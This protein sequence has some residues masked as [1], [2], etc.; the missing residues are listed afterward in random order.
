MNLWDAKQKIIAMTMAVMMLPWSSFNCSF[1]RTDRS[2]NKDETVIDTAS[3]TDAINNDISID[4]D[5]KN[6]GGIDNQN[7]DDISAILDKYKND[8]YNDSDIDN[9]IPFDE[10]SI[11]ISVG[12]KLESDMVVDGH[13]VLDSGTLDLNGHKLTVKGDFLHS[14]GIVDINN[15]LLEIYGSYRM[16]KY[17]VDDMG[18]IVY[19]S[20]DSTLIMN[21]SNDKIL[22]N[23]DFIIDTIHDNNDSKLLS[24]GNIE[25]KGDICFDI[26]T[27]KTGFMP[28]ENHTIT[29]SSD[30]EQ[31]ISYSYTKGYT[32]NGNNSHIR[33]IINLN[34]SE[35]G[36]KIKEPLYISGKIVTGDNKLSGPIMI[37]SETTFDNDYFDGD[38]SILQNIRFDSAFT[39]NGNLTV[40]KMSN[41][42]GCTINDL[43]TV[44]GDVYNYYIIEGNG[45][46]VVNGNMYNEI[47]LYV[48]DLS[49]SGNL[50]N[51]YYVKV[52]S[53]YVEGDVIADDKISVI[54]GHIKGSLISNEDN[55]MFYY[56]N[57]NVIVEGD[58]VNITFRSQQS[59]SKVCIYGNYTTNGLTF[60]GDACE[61]L[62]IKGNIEIPGD[63]KVYAYKLILSGDSLQEIKNADKLNIKILEIENHSTEG[64][65]SDSIISYDTL[66][67]NNYNFSYGATNVVTGWTLEDDEIIE[68]DLVL[69]EGNLDLKGHKL[70]IEGDLVQMSGKVILNNGT[71]DIKGSY[72]MQSFSSDEDRENE[73]YNYGRASLIMSYDKDEVIISKDFV[74]W[75]KADNTRNLTSGTIKLGGNLE[76]GEDSSKTAFVCSK[77]LKIYMNGESDQKIIAKNL[78]ELKIGKL[79]LDSQGT[80]YADTAL[81]IMG[82]LTS[83]MD[84][85]FEG[86][87]IIDSKDVDLSGSGFAGDISIGERYFY[88]NYTIGG[89]LD[90]VGGITIDRGRNLTVK[91]N[92]NSVGYFDL[93]GTLITEG[94]YI[95]NKENGITGYGE[96]NLYDNSK[97][98]VNGNAEFK[99]LSLHFYNKNKD[100]VVEIGGDFICRAEGSY[101]NGTIYVGGD[102]ITGNNSFYAGD[103]NRVILNGDRL[104]TVDIGGGCKL[105]TLELNNHS[106]AGVVA[107]TVFN[108][109]SLINHD[110]NF[111]YDGLSGIDGYK[112]DN[113]LEYNGDLIIIDG[114]MDLDG[115]TL[116]VVNGDLILMG[117]A[118]DINK[119][120]LIVEGNLR[121]QIRKGDEGNYTYATSESSIIMNDPED[122]IEIEGSFYN[123]ITKN[124]NGKIT[125]GI[126]RLSG[127]YIVDS[128]SGI[129]GFYPT[130]NSKLILTDNDHILNSNITS[131]NGRFITLS[132]LYVEE[133]ENGNNTISGSDIII[134]SSIKPGNAVFE[135]KITLNKGAHIEGNRINADIT[136]N[137][138]FDR[139]YGDDIESDDS[140]LTINGNVDGKPNFYIDTVINGNLSGIST[141]NSTINLSGN[142]NGTSTINGE[143]T[144]GGN[145]TG[146]ATI[147]NNVTVKGSVNLTGITTIGNA[148]L[149][150]SKALTLSGLVLNNRN[151]YIY[152]GSSFNYTGTSTPSIGSLS[153]GV[154]EVKGNVD[155]NSG[156][157]ADGE[158]KII[159]SGNGKQTIDTHNKADIAILELKNKSSIGVNSKSILFYDEIICNESKLTYAYE[160]I[161]EDR[162]LDSDIEYYGDSYFVDGVLDLN[163]HTLTV[164]GNL[165]HMNGIIKFNGGKLIV[166]G[167]LKE[168]IKELDKGT[169]RYIYSSGMGILVMASDRDVLDVDGSLN[170]YNNSKNTEIESGTIYVG[171]DFD[172]SSGLLL[173]KN[174]KI[175]MD[176]IGRQ[177]IG[178]G[179]STIPSLVI[180][181]TGYL[182]IKN[183]NFTVTDELASTNI[184]NLAWIRVPSLNIVEGDYYGNIRLV[185]KDILEKDLT[186]NG[187]LTV[188]NELDINGYSLYA[189][190]LSFNTYLGKLVM[191]SD[192][193]YIGLTGSFQYYGARGSR[194]TSGTVELNSDLDLTYAS[195]FYASGDHKFIINP[196][197]DKTIKIKESKYDDSKINTLILR[198]RESEFELSGDPEKIANEILYEYDDKPLDAVSDLRADNIN[199]NSATIHF[200]DSSDSVAVGYNI[201]RDNSLI[202]VT[203]DRFFV[204]NTVKPDSSYEYKVVSFGK[205]GDT[206]PVSSILNVTIPK[207]TTPPSAPDG[208]AIESK[209][210]S[211]ITISWNESDDDVCVAGYNVYRNGDLLPDIEYELKDSLII[212]RDD[213]VDPD[214]DTVY[215]YKIEAYDDAGNRSDKSE[216]ISTAV[217]K[218]VIN[219]V[220]PNNNSEINNENARLTVY[221]KNYGYYSANKLDIEYLDEDNNWIMINTAALTHKPSLNKELNL[222][223][224]F[225]TSVIT[226]SSVKVRFTLTDIDGNSVEEEVTYYID[227]IPPNKIENLKAENKSGVIFLSWD[228]PTKDSDVDH[229]EIYRVNVGA[230]S[231]DTYLGSTSSVNDKTF[232]DKNTVEGQTYIYKV[233]AVD[234]NGNMI[235]VENGDV[236]SVEV[237]A[238]KDIVLPEIINL[239]P[240]AGRVSGKVGLNAV[241]EDNKASDE[242]VFF[243][244]WSDENE[245]NILSVTDALSS[246]LLAGNWIKI[247]NTRCERPSPVINVST[248]WN[249]LDLPDGIYQIK[250]EAVDA[251]GNHSDKEFIRRYVVDNTGISQINIT[252]IKTG[253]TYVQLMWD[254]VTE[255]DFS[256]FS[257]EVMGDNG[258][259]SEIYKEYDHTGYI[260]DG[261]KP[262]K[263]Y[264]FR[265]MGVDDLGN[266]GEYSDVVTVKTVNDN[267]PP[268]ITSISPSPCR[269]KNSIDLK[270][271]AK[272]NS[273]LSAALWSY[274]FDGYNFSEIARVSGSGST[275]EFR[276]HFDISDV[277]K[278]PE[279]HIYIKSECF[280]ASGNMNALMEGEKEVIAEY[281]I[282]RTAPHVPDNF[283]VT[284]HEGNIEV[285]WDKSEQ[286]NDICLYRIY[287]SEK[288]K[289]SDSFGVYRKVGETKDLNWYDTSVKSGMSYSY[290]IECIDLAGNISNRTDPICVTAN[291][292]NINPEVK[293]ISPQENSSVGQSSE[294]TYLIS[295]NTELGSLIVY[296]RHCSDYKTSQIVDKADDEYEI[297]DN[298]WSEIYRVNHSGRYAQS[299]FHMDFSDYEE[300]LYDFR[301]VVL[302]KSGNRSD[303]FIRTFK[304][305]K[306]PCT[307][308]IYPNMP[309]DFKCFINLRLDEE[310]SSD[311]DYMEIYRC[312]SDDAPTDFDFMIKARKIGTSVSHTGYEDKTVVSGVRYSYAAKLY[313]KYGNYSWTNIVDDKAFI[314][315]KVAPVINTTEKI[316]SIAGYSFALSAGASTDNVKIKSFSWD[317]GNGIILDGANTE[318]KYDN[319]GNYSIKLTVT[320]TSGNSSDKVIPVQVKEDD[321]SG[322]CKVVVKDSAGCP[323]PYA[324]VYINAPG[325]NECFYMTD[326]SGEVYLAYKAGNYKIA[327]YK[328]G[329]LPS[330][331]TAE[332]IGGEIKECIISLASGEVIQG[333]FEIHRMTLEEII[334]SG[335]DLSDPANLNTFTFTTSLTFEK[336]PIPVVVDEI[337][338]GIEIKGNDIDKSGG[339]T[340]VYF[341][342]GGQGPGDIRG[343]YKSDVMMIGVPAPEPVP[344][345]VVLQTTQT[346]SWLKTMYSANLTIFNAADSKYVIEDAMGS[347]ELPQGVSLVHLGSGNNDPSCSVISA[348]TEEVDMGHINGQEKKRVSW[349]IKGDRSGSYRIKAKFGGTL[350]P[351]NVHVEKSFIAEQKMEVEQADVEILVMPESSA[352]IGEKYYIQYAITN[353]GNEPL[354]NFTTS[355]GDREEPAKK[356][357]VHIMDPETGVITSIEESVEGRSY[358]IPISEQIYQ[359]PVL[360]GDDEITIPTLLPGQTIYGTWCL[361]A[362]KSREIFT[363][364]HLKEFYELKNYVV[365]AVSEYN[366]GVKV[367][368][369]PIDSHISKYISTVWKGED[370]RIVLGDPVDL[371]SG[372]FTDS[373][374]ALGFIG[375]DILSLDMQYDSR[376]AALCDDKASVTDADKDVNA[377]KASE[378]DAD[379][380][381][382]DEYAT[383]TD[384]DKDT[385]MIKNTCGYGWYNDFDTWIEEKNGIL[386]Y[387]INPYVCVPFISE[388]S[389]EGSLYG[390]LDDEG[391]VLSDVDTDSDVRYVSFL[392]NTDGYNLTRHGD[393]SYSLEVPSGSRFIYDSDGRLTQY[394]SESGS[395]TDISYLQNADGGITE[396]VTEKISGNTLILI[397]DSNGLLRSVS[398]NA[399]RVS[400]FDYDEKGNLISITNPLGEKISYNYDSPNGY[401]L[402]TRSEDNEGE[403]IVENSYDDIGRVKSQIDSAGTILRFDYNEQTDG[404]LKTVVTSVHDDITD[405]TTIIS[406]NHGFITY[407]EDKT[408]NVSY[409]YDSDDNL[410]HLENSNGSWTDYSYYESGKMTSVRQ[411]T[412]DNVNLRYDES[413]NIIEVSSISESEKPELENKANYSYD[414]KGRLIEG[415]LYGNT[416]RYAYDDEGTLVSMETEGR[417]KC[418]FTSDKGR[419]TSYTNEL[420][421]SV[422]VTYDS[423]GNI[424]SVTN[425]AGGVTRYT[426]DAM[427]RLISVE[428]PLGGVTRYTYNSLGLVTTETDPLGNTISYS[429]DA[430]G[431]CT[432]IKYPDGSETGLS[433]D[434]IGRLIEKEF[435]DGTSEKY[436]YDEVGKVRSVTYS[437]G[438]VET[439]S[440]NDQGMLSEITDAIG[441][442]TGYGYDNDGKLTR[443]IASNGAETDIAYT[444]KDISEISL[445]EISSS[446]TYNSI[447]LINSETDPLGNTATYEYDS[448]GNMISA[449]DPNGNKTIYGYDQIGRCSDITYP[450]G[451]KV[452]QKYDLS[453]NVTDIRTEV[454]GKEI[455][456]SYAYDKAGLLVSATDESG[457]KTSY[458]Y[459]IAGRLVKVEDEFGNYSE[460]KYDCMGRI[461]EESDNI[462]NSVKYEYDICGNPVHV[463]S[464]LVSEDNKDVTSKNYSYSYD[465]L[466]RLINVTDPAGKITSQEYDKLGQVTSVTDA[467]GGVTEYSY[468]RSGNLTEVKDPVGNITQYEY[469]SYGN[470]V[471]SIDARGNKTEYSYDKCGRLTELND[472]EGVIKYSY[473]ANGNLLT[474]SDKS[475]TIT[476]TYDEMDRVSSFTDCNGNTLKYGYDELGNI[477]SITYPGGE[478]VR[479]SYNPDGTL[480]EM[481]DGSGRKTIY[482][483]D[484]QG[485]KITTTRPDGSVETLTYDE[486]SNIT[487]RED[488]A[489]SGK[490]LQRYEYSYDE[491]G[492][493]TAVKETVDNDYKTQKEKDEITADDKELSSSVTTSMEYDAAN[494]LIRYN[495]SE[496]KY[497]EDGN[498]VYGPLDGKMVS[499]KYDSR[500]RLI[501]ADGVRYSYD[502]ENIRISAESDEYSEQY[503]TDRVCLLSRTLE[504]RRSN[505]KNENILTTG[506]SVTRLYYGTGLVYDVTVSDNGTT[507]DSSIKSDISNAADPDLHGDVRIYHFDHLGSTRYITDKTGKITLYF[508]YGTFGEFIGAYDERFNE[509]ELSEAESPVR[510]LYNGEYG[511]S[512]DSNGLLYMRQRYYNTDIK[513]FINRD[514]ISGSILESQSLNRYSYVE[515][516]PVNYLD[517]F[518]LSKMLN[519][520]ASIEGNYHALTTFMSDPINNTLRAANR[521]VRA[522]GKVWSGLDTHTKLNILGALPGIGYVFDIA[523]SIK[524]FREGEVEKGVESL[525]FALPTLNLYGGSGTIAKFITGSEHTAEI[526][527]STVQLLGTSTAAFTASAKSIKGLAGLINTYVIG[528]AELDENFIRDAGETFSYLAMTTSFGM[529]MLKDYNSYYRATEAVVY[530]RVVNDEVIA[531][532]TPPEDTR[533]S[534]LIEQSKTELASCFV[535]G[536]RIKTAEG[537]KNIEDIQAG[538]E[539]Y[540]C[541]V[542]TGE[543]G[544]KKVKRTFIHE[545]T[546]IVH[547]TIENTTIETTTEHPFYVEGYGFKYA[548]DLQPGDEIRQLDGTTAEV[549]KIEYEYLD[550][551]IYVYNFEVEDWHTY[552]V[553][554]IG[555]L[556]HND[557]MAPPP[558]S[559]SEIK[560]GSST[561]KVPGRVQSRIN[562]AKGQTRYTP[563]DKNGNVIDAGWNHVVKRHFNGELS[564][565]TSKFTITQDE[566][567]KIL[568]SDNTVSATVKSLDDG[569][570][571]RTVDTGQIIGN[572]SLKYGGGPTSW[573]KVFTD[574]AG[575]IITTYPIPEP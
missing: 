244:R 4:Y 289:D 205:Y 126:I 460:Y 423:Y 393:G 428:N 58:C 180:S 349:I 152:V 294:I 312:E 498:M 276:N 363:G 200:K 67:G 401:H 314:P 38:I 61:V 227:N 45:K 497:D 310:F 513:R 171:K 274:S 346:V 225:D 469:D 518:G 223:C 525:I 99:G 251:S 376:F 49:V 34:S 42:T 47:G 194:L 446:V 151:S 456:Y 417:G 240:S 313:D 282:D 448:F 252:D 365:T 177:A 396:T 18:E 538:D 317:M 110:S 236:S 539:V 51:N 134:T 287:R 149:S 301:F 529:M 262:Q 379:I 9:T 382:L 340:E 135:N 324:Y 413:G 208:L 554:D 530:G 113:D 443:I 303:D 266:K 450:N 430:S 41:G 458:S 510:Y 342:E 311:F 273:D 357:A 533:K 527:G 319:P 429:Y 229:Y 275:Y 185:G 186:I 522:V 102:F 455:K 219:K 575:N 153:Q 24:S 515:G 265:V 465:K 178:S 445:G 369:K 509:I 472:A 316:T 524:Y 435:A 571:V 302:D 367:I 142:L 355:I 103:K 69:S 384:A 457:R 159:L 210:G 260:A 500:N 172:A 318:Y 544:L 332:I 329:Y 54:G 74:I 348:D 137:N 564:Q 399:G 116:K 107:K 574:K 404:G 55:N 217:A 136:C 567:K 351:F 403:L 474:V 553:S 309:D 234:N 53:L 109:D 484:R 256:Y 377:K 228:R 359:M 476:R 189:H 383:V 52:N 321:N 14:A 272:D 288:K 410:I 202:G 25:V 190:D 128:Q 17:S 7:I 148:K 239:S 199:V 471:R 72:R 213:S 292:D 373:Y 542:E 175:V 477:L 230:E 514:I 65:I 366:P 370:E 512:T 386:H 131:G 30:K 32:I 21:D 307:G 10:D 424:N 337:P 427:D 333:D 88:Y 395:I 6:T 277:D 201:Y 19:S 79:E 86:R 433:Y 489:A 215:E 286:E 555:A 519:T 269:V 91:K 255:N 451:L 432:V 545:E 441:N 203:A 439:L 138:V 389:K 250:A 16:Q 304:I 449:V 409:V 431:R 419:L 391:I 179:V 293:G 267:I 100:A 160:N 364:D 550:E 308:M 502:A 573:I 331:Q 561:G 549:Q 562:I 406:N 271:S 511:V 242:V 78:D 467:M 43:L 85:K 214:N 8:K 326:G 481:T 167:D 245:D 356:T 485:R 68:G 374:T 517:P 270:I 93:Y 547:V 108:K 461:L 570:F 11:N 50:Y 504:I 444:G 13:F 506:K 80:I 94:N 339:G 204:D 560:G 415:T 559:G 129:Y 133:S 81:R 140:K 360:S 112:L 480:A 492:N 232:E 347:I 280:D 122:S 520:L 462:G 231:K 145:M 87:I 222:S 325:D 82:G 411:S 154:I 192:S 390:R 328:E 397:K 123:S 143:L 2:V 155:L 23:Q 483:Y 563:L 394:I 486:R 468:D 305:D 438:S 416:V 505:K 537:D 442:V 422:S 35:A 278:F 196:L 59:S 144:V 322:F 487:I 62:E 253:A 147:N 70:T 548:C 264:K 97:M 470:L 71:L 499:F 258:E 27:G 536:T 119:G 463:T 268:V 532:E 105:A 298:T 37:S 29:M 495:G 295:D 327:A 407:G 343:P 473:N 315:D 558:T 249:T 1:Q 146:A 344:V 15:G 168:Q 174:V 405:I 475:G 92:I 279:G 206:S 341:G 118:L 20:A 336:R 156:F 371:T 48:S 176:G 198:G 73:K 566:L 90:C 516:N 130:G 132:N 488:K 44:T 46:L 76:I 508:D 164:N 453:G 114:V 257:V 551:P 421:A 157:K 291:P 523:N 221:F 241:A 284:V 434:M 334:E 182:E 414:D 479:Y 503:V 296:I 381:T 543:V 98:F 89:N 238:G 353:N 387:Y 127:D 12:A 385:D 354:Y 33:N 466:G 491:Y 243:Y 187:N 464:C 540:A 125:D 36:V 490:T 173:G 64:I 418:S 56:E 60:I 191:E 557:C 352:Y 212:F 496:V 521:T 528:G 380:K 75:S 437:D 57:G 161:I 285:S 299:S 568:Q 247:N 31:L 166:K 478:I 300:G 22:I 454:D 350:M 77:N 372:A 26:R 507:A 220:I 459:D 494:R 531:W 209:S 95:G 193:D 447:G 184:S 412:G 338:G 111:R 541:D 224:E 28:S 237:T 259:F 452:E 534:E 388:K 207:D 106:D 83:D 211:S 141:L 392:A 440:Y 181:N 526:V 124:N 263:E 226:Q 188:E 306:T 170:L 246:E 197:E 420:G 358:V 361:S 120:K 248:E 493:I 218:P 63:S 408:G 283:S 569:Q 233:V 115:H 150:V 216:R 254:D 323:I 84:D 183:S 165:N 5:Q 368:V 330:E 162:I 101:R 572:T 400:A 169:N 436:S 281:I 402:M 425:P 158:N 163:G 398:D 121:Q 552:Y 290:Q 235:D 195:A 297:V 375:K 139:I 345:V 320:D 482:G 556:V 565:G 362:E 3:D 378:S 535:A 66:K 96:V 104:Q 117:G 39:V 261:L 335:V 426:Y 501:E 546:L 40:T